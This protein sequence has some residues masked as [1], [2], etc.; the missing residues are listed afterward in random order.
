MYTHIPSVN[1]KNCHM[2]A[3]FITSLRYTHVELHSNYR[4]TYKDYR[5][6]LDFYISIL[7]GSEG[8][9]QFHASVAITSQ[10]SPTCLTEQKAKCTTVLRI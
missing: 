3:G 10:E 6:T 7:D 9:C 2:T 4:E 8:N 1:P 5:Q